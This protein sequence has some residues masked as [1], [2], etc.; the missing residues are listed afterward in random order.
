MIKGLCLL[1]ILAPIIFA[2]ASPSAK[3]DTDSALLV[4]TEGGRL[5]G[6]AQDGLRVF[7]GIPFAAPPLGALRWRPPAPAPRWSG[8]RRADHF[9]DSCM[10]E[11]RADPAFGTPALTVSEDCLYLNVWTPARSASDHLPVMVWIYGGGFNQGSTAIPLYSGEQLAAHGVVVV[12][13]AYRVGP[14]GFLA[15]AALTAES[16]H[17]SS[18]NYG[19]LDQIAALQW[20]QRNIAKFGGDPHKVTIFGESA[21]GI[22]VSMLAASPLA[23]GLFSGAISES[24]GSFGPTRDPP[25]PGEN[26]LTLAEA[27]R[28]GAAFAQKLGAQTAAELRRLPAQTVQ[29]AAAGHGL[30]WPVVDG[31]VILGDQYRLYQEGRF[32]D[33][34]I[35]IGTNS[36]EG[37]LFGAPTSRQ[38]YIDA[39]HQRYG[40]YAQR[41]LA[42]YPAT[43]TAWRQSSMDLTRDAAFG[44][45]TWAWARLQSRGGHSKVFCY[46]FEH[47][48]PRPASSRWREA[49]GAVHSEEMVYVFGHLNQQALPWTSA[50][51]TLSDEMTT[52]WTNF[53]KHGDPNSAGIP[54]WPAFA[55]ADPQV[56]R[57]TDPPHAGSVPN[58]AGL[59]VLDAYFA[60]RRTPAGAAWVRKER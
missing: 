50:D 10:Q 24:G 39:V 57:L 56:M 18:G 23:R 6:V 55:G 32:N 17:H 22:A 51:R 60:W 42:V 37:A 53:A 21:G 34:P 16:S 46:Y 54:E 58:L 14:L 36:D 13:I 1:T 44:W 7:L 59:E 38:A 9:A 49:T 15:H 33:T 12:S 47:V 48:P 52:Y 30:F 31:W 35:L 20:I 28:D 2:G 11:S 45:P 3:A 29:Q 4:R 19:L 40:P 25:L 43:E 5:L 27:E 41:L 26:M 8:V